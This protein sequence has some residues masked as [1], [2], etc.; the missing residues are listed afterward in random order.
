[1]STKCILGYQIAPN[2]DQKRKESN[3]HR[4]LCDEP[5]NCQQNSANDAGIEYP[6]NQLKKT[7]WNQRNYQPHQCE[8]HFEFHRL[9]LL[10]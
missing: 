2:P 1:M 3:G 10:V 7:R 9:L 8:E 6:I 4:Y 5:T